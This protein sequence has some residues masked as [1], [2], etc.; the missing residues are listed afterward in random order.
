MMKVIKKITAITCLLVLFLINALVATA[1]NNEVVDDVYFSTNNDLYNSLNSDEVY[2][3]FTT[4]KYHFSSDEI[5]NVSYTFSSNTHIMEIEYAEIGFEIIN[6]SGDSQEV[7]KLNIEVRC[8]SN[9]I[10][11]F[12][13]IDV[14]LSNSQKQSIYLC[15]IKNESGVFISP[16][17]LDNAYSKYEYYAKSNGL[18][19]E[20]EIIVF[21]DAVTDEISAPSLELSDVQVPFS[22]EQTE[23]VSSVSSTDSLTG[24]INVEGELVWYDDYAIYPHP[25]RRVMVKLFAKTGLGNI[26]IGT[27]YILF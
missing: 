16:Y 23:I 27:T 8:L 11:S 26:L 2:V 6:I 15:A 13:N 3:C 9:A 5:I 1:H 12:I 7:N 4:D 21:T 19:E 25:V 10:E 22:A 24:Y 17:S 18:I 14:N 20:Q